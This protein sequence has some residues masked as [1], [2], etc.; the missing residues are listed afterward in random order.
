MEDSEV[1][2]LKDRIRTIARLWIRNT[3]SNC[4]EAIR[5]SELEDMWESKPTL[6][7]EHFMKEM[8]HFYVRSL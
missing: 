2:S 7:G 6:A 3:V 8:K 1:I 4:C 5:D